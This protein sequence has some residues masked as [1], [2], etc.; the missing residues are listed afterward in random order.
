[1][2]NKP[3]IKHFG[4]FATLVATT[5]GMN[6]L[7]FPVNMSKSMNNNG[8]Y[9][10]IILTILVYIFAILIFRLY[11]KYNFNSI[12]E[13]FETCCGK[14]V[15]KILF[16]ILSFFS[17]MY[18]GIILNNFSKIIKLYLFPKTPISFFILTMCIL[19]GY[20][21]KN[22]IR[23]M[24][25]FNEVSFFMIFIPMAIVF[26]FCVN[27]GDYSNLLPFKIED[28]NHILKGAKNSLY[29]FSGIEILYLYFPYLS[30][31]K[32]TSRV[33][34]RS[35]M[36][37]CLANLIIYVL[38]LFNFGSNHLKMLLNPTLTLIKVI[39]VP[40]SFLER[41]EGI[42]ISFWIFFCFTSA[43][44]VS[45]FAKEILCNTFKIRKNM[46][47]LMVLIIIVIFSVWDELTN[48]FTNFYNNSF[49]IYQLACYLIIPL[50]FNILLKIKNEKRSIK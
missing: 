50:I 29:I 18:V 25:R 16:L 45:F 35:F 40:G 7:Y 43:I 27:K 8:W 14:Y 1:M 38:C 39:E 49:Y 44:N 28:L 10:T 21:I 2:D 19:I 41:W 17:L 48:L 47:I 3:F 24:V 4:L 34:L 30:S 31:K 46:T 9:I 20:G 11:D 36:F 12:Y 42:V 26:S 6:I 15:S 22:S 13:L 37:I 23:G 5:I 32:D 33:L